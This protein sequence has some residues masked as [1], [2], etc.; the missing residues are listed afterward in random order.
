MIE[1]PALRKFIV[2]YFLENSTKPVFEVVRGVYTYLKS[3]FVINE[4]VFVKTKEKRAKVKS[5]TGETY[6]V[7]FGLDGDSDL[8]SICFQDME[9]KEYIT[10]NSILSFIESI[11]MM[12]PFGRVLKENI[13][14]DISLMQRARRV[15][16]TTGRYGNACSLNKDGLE[17]SEDVSKVGSRKYTNTRSCLSKESLEEVV[18]NQEESIPAAQEGVDDYDLSKCDI[19]TSDFIESEIPSATEDPERSSFTVKET[20]ER[21]SDTQGVQE[22]SSVPPKK[23]GGDSSQGKRKFSNIKDVLKTLE[24][25]KIEVEGIEDLVLFTEIYLFFDCFKEPFGFQPT[26]EEFGSALSDRSYSSDIAFV[27]HKTLLCILAEEIQTLSRYQYKQVFENAFS[28]CIDIDECDFNVQPYSNYNWMEAEITEKNWK[29]MMKNFFSYL[30]HV[31]GLQKV[32]CYREFFIKTGSNF[33]VDR[34]RIL[35]FMIECVFSTNKFKNVVNSRLEELRAVEKKSQ[36]IIL[37]IKKLKSE[38]ADTS[39]QEKSSRERVLELESELLAVKRSLLDMGYKREI[40]YTE[41]IH[42][43][44]FENR[45][46]FLEDRDMYS[47]DPEQVKKLLSIYAPKHRSLSYLISALKRYISAFPKVSPTLDGI[48]VNK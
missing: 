12:S 44:Y 14:Q 27:A 6:L 15:R 18:G 20:K 17:E 9:R 42:F 3:N 48:L 5:F 46:C 26:K 43:F 28:I 25:E 23:I 31:H 47:L 19:Q 45:I 41:G 11:T 22:E 39:S 24:Y 2:I 36:D 29:S 32:T 21:L 16:K 8:C 35:K 34:M 37:Q 7:N 13:L 33:V 38:V 30:Y 10:K 40:A 1:S 4:T